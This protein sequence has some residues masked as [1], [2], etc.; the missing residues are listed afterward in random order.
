MNAET[1]TAIASVISI[2]AII[3]GPILA[4][5][6]GD[7]LQRRAFVRN[8]RLSL[9]NNLMATRSSVTAPDRLRSL[10]LIDVVFHGETK[11]IDKWRDYHD[12]MSNPAFN[13][14]NGATEVFS[15]NET[16]RCA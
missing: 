8:Q 6:V 1:V 9:F 12:A 13:D 16:T 5:R 15:S 11:V 2:V 10:S 7:D 14:A 4:V 3:A